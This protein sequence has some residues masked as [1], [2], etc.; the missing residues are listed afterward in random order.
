MNLAERIDNLLKQ[1]GRNAQIIADA[2][3]L[4]PGTLTHWRKGDRSPNAEDLF[5][6]VKTLGVSLDS[7]F[8]YKAEPM[9]LR[10]GPSP[11][12]VDEVAA[13]MDDAMQEMK[14]LA[15]AIQK[16]KRVSS[17]GRTS[18]AQAIGA[19]QGISYDQHRKK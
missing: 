2:A 8:D 5:R 10:D 18:A 4:S 7:L 11:H 12:E 13:R 1:D 14:A 6:L 17:T 19:Q 15:T 3:E 16:L 9:L